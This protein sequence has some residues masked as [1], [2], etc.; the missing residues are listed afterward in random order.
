MVKK[1]FF[2]ILLLTLF[3]FSCM[4]YDANYIIPSSNTDNSTD[5][6]TDDDP[7]DD[8]D[9]PTTSYQNLY[10][11]TYGNSRFI[12]VGNKGKILYSDNGSSWDNGTS[13]I[14]TRLEEL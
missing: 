12:A 6:S 13:G 14:N 2:F 7:I 3:I 5:N 9:T 4:D 1:L 11:I 10:G 8:D